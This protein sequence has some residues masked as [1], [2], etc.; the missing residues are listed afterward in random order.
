MLK[1]V[2]FFVMMNW[3]NSLEVFHHVIRAPTLSDYRVKCKDSYTLTI[4]FI[5]VNYTCEKNVH[6]VICAPTLFCRWSDGLIKKGWKTWSA[7]CN[8]SISKS[9]MVYH[10]ILIDRRCSITETIK[11][12][13][14]WPLKT[15]C[16]FFHYCFMN[17][18]VLSCN[19]CPVAVRCV[20]R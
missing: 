12:Y 18:N 8:K 14:S 1:F 5:F 7:L 13:I 3:R 10:V 16:I 19:T 20:E 2:S 11:K 6:H 4:N 15:S 9:R 17:G